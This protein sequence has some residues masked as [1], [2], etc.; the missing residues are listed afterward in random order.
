MA[1]VKFVRLNENDPFHGEVQPHADGI[2]GDHHFRLVAGKQAYLPAADLRRK[3]SVDDTGT[4]AVSLQP[5]RDIQNGTFGEHDQGVPLLY[6][7]READGDR[8]AHQR[9]FAFITVN[10]A[11]IPTQGNQV[12]DYLFGGGTH[13]Y[14]DLLCLHAQN[15]SGPGMA[16][17]GIGYHLCLIDDRHLIFLVDV[18]HFHGG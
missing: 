14:M 15:G 2:G 4:D 13:A 5:S 8:L 7:L 10:F 18:Q 3:A 16:P 17:V 12:G 1:A 9:G 6:I 11:G